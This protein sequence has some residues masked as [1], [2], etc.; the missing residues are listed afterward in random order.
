MYE[1]SE[2]PSRKVY[3]PLGESGEGVVG[4]KSG[5][6]TIELFPDARLILQALFEG[7]YGD[8]V[9]I[10]AASSADTPQ[11]VKIGRTAMTILEI[12]P[13]VTMR[14]AFAKGWPQGFEGNMQ[15]GRSPPLSSDK[16]STHFPILR[17]ETGVD[18]NDMDVHLTGDKLRQ[19]HFIWHTGYPGGLKQRSVRDQLKLKPEEVLRK[20][21]LGMLAKNNLRYDIARK[22]RI[23]PG[24]KHFHE[25]KLPPGTP[26]VL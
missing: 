19:K 1:L 10:A 2:I 12:L 17:Q 3:G 9:R 14:D 25:D 16:A 24:P 13:G 11:A 4:V 26:S 23:F 22:L 21:V 5:R 20:S 6:E 7:K 15:I 18:Y 8:D